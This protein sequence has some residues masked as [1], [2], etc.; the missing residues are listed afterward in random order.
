[1]L[2]L[3]VNLKFGFE[4]F[5]RADMT[6]LFNWFFIM[7]LFSL[8]GLLICYWSGSHKQRVAPGKYSTFDASGIRLNVNEPI[9]LYITIKMLPINSFITLNKADE[10]DDLLIMNLKED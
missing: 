3:I 6:R 1:M 9:S 7:V 8:V 5:S 4:E 2:E 10:S